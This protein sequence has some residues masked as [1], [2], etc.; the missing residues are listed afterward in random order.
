MIKVGDRT[1]T[2]STNNTTTSTAKSSSTATGDQ[3][4]S[5]LLAQLQ[6]QNPLEPMNDTEMVNQMVQLNSLTEL[7][8]ISKALTSMTQTNQFV[9]AT[10]LIDKT[11]T[12]LNSDNES[13]S[14]TVSGVFMNKS[15]VFLKVDDKN[16]ALDSVV[17][18]G[19]EEG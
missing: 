13:V 1:Y 3:F 8:K 9:S 17:S 14:G 11:V 16:V 6:N 15:S 2:E 7:Q 4:M 19:V 10:S 18:V 5:L 12:Y